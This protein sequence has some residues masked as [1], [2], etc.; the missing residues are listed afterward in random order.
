MNRFSFH[1]AFLIAAGASALIA[2]NPSG[3]GSRPQKAAADSRQQG[4]VELLLVASSPATPR[5]A[6]RPW[7]PSCRS[8]GANEAAIAKRLSHK[9]AGVR[10]AALRIFQLAV[11]KAPAAELTAL[12]AD[13]NDAVREAAVIYIA[14]CRPPG[15]TAT[16]LRVVSVDKHPSIRRQ[17]IVGLGD[18]GDL[19]VVP[20]LTGLLAFVNDEYLARK[21]ATALQSLTGE[22]RGVDQAAWE[23]WWVE[24]GRERLSA[25]ESARVERALQEARGANPK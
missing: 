7:P 14:A 12:T 9:E 24:T 18:S 2:Q 4:T 5:S 13:Q 3:P 15:W 16:L 11:L 21:V 20:D 6:R 8:R 25:Q 17:A 19:S 10:Q 22:T 23:R 1:V